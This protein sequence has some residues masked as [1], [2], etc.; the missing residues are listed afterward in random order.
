VLY[1]VNKADQP[2]GGVR[3]VR[4]SFVSFALYGA[5]IVNMKHQLICSDLL[6]YG[7]NSSRNGIT[8]PWMTQVTLNDAPFGVDCHN[9]RLVKIPKD[10]QNMFLSCNFPVRIIL[11]VFNKRDLQVIS[12]IL[13][14]EPN[15]F[16]NYNVVPLIEL[17][18]SRT[19]HC[20]M[21]KKNSFNEIWNIC[22][23]GNCIVTNS[24]QTFLEIISGLY[25]ENQFLERQ[26]LLHSEILPQ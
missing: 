10:S 19:S 25:H 4:K 18:E 9:M 16:G 1:P 3:Y 22:E 6:P 15:L 20:L 17:F 21:E 8:F 5:C 13:K 11:G 23:N 12:K 7:K 14:I 26:L 2:A 24:C